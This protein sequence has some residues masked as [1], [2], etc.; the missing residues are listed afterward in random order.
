MEVIF[1]DIRKTIKEH[2]LRQWEIAEIMEIS[3]CTLSIWLRRPDKLPQYKRESIE[4]AIEKLIA[5][6]GRNIV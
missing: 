5:M 3:E 6:G 2:K 4:A 1:M